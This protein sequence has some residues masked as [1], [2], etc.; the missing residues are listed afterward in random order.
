MSRKLLSGALLPLALLAAAPASAI[1]FTWSGFG[2]L[3]YAQSDREF[4]YQRFIND[5]GTF[6]RDSVLGGQLDMR[7][8][9]QFGATVQAKLAPSDRYDRR[10]HTPLTWAFVSWRPSDDWLIRVGKLRLPLMLNTENVDVGA[11]FDFARL[12][13]EVYSVSPITDVVGL[14]LSK[15]W[16][17]DNYDWVVEAY[18]GQAK[19]YWRYYGRNINANEASPGS[20]Y[21][22]VDVK[23][24][25]LVLTA[26]SIDQTFRVGIHEAEVA[27]VGA[28][29][30]AQISFH[31][32]AP[33]V[34]VYSL[35][36]GG[37]DQLIIPVYTVS[38]SFLLPAD[39]RLTS[40][41]AKM[42]VNSASA[43]LG[44]WGAYA[45]LSKR[46]GAWVPYISYAR[47]K[48]TDAALDRYRA[49]N[50]N[51]LPPPFSVLNNTQTLLADI[52]DPFDQ[53]TTALGTSYRL[54]PESLIKAEWSVVRTGVAS[55]LVDAPSGEDSGHRRIN[56]FS[57]SY[58]FTF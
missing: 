2:T 18:T 12:P 48:S 37:V 10:W 44:R 9:Q 31:P 17:G 54:T 34:G 3:G 45:A 15:T 21:L 8:S 23:S 57:I 30:G 56:I 52:V 58:S 53:S 19:A 28:K 47:M 25:G 43:G 7:F 46:I 33:G 24:S 16:F 29:T 32:L 1:D 51:R 4:N 39:I 50:G 42:R 36:S 41:Y 5:D 11:T 40:E 27:R 49:I 14:S 20:W 55:S 13:Q 22:P 26:R 6:K 38:A 35:D